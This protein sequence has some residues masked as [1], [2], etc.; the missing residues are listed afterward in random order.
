MKKFVA[1]ALFAVM[2][3]FAASATAPN[4]DFMLVVRA[5]PEP[6]TNE[7]RLRPV[8]PLT[9]DLENGEKATIENAWF[10]VVGD[11]VVRFVE[12][13]EHTMRNLS[14]AE[15]EGHGMTAEQA[16]DVAMA[17]I[18]K[19]YGE[20]DAVERDGGIWT[21]EG[22]SPD[23]INS[24]LL[25]REFWD[26]QLAQHPEGLVVGLPTRDGL[27]FAS[28]E[29]SEAVETLSIS[30]PRIHSEAGSQAISPML[31]EYRDGRWS[32]YRRTDPS[33]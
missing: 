23:L 19:R 3:V 4:D 7:P 27:A 9:F 31:F 33:G 6:P 13:G 24:Y 5:G 30:V 28:L 12:D 22:R 29:N 18:V 17:N 32:V 14:Q 16:V 25:H 26:R 10:W 21:V 1:A 2:P 11:L 15:F 8:G 20:P